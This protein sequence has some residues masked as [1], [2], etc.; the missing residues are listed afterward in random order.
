MGEFSWWKLLP[1]GPG[2]GAETIVTGGIVTGCLA[3][4]TGTWYFA[5]PVA[6]DA[7]N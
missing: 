2:K 6:V 4:A 1:A 3:L 7:K 5:P